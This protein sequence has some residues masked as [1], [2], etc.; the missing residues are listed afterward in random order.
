MYSLDTYISTNKCLP[1]DFHIYSPNSR[2]NLVYIWPYLTYKDGHFW[3]QLII[4]KLLENFIFSYIVL[5][6]V[7]LASYHWAFN[8]I[9]INQHLQCIIYL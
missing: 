7:F 6:H 3:R 8:N 4:R 9:A 1:C 2:L 5:F